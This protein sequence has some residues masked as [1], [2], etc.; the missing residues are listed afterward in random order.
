LVTIPQRG[1]RVSWGIPVYPA[2][3]DNPRPLM[4]KYHET[5]TGGQFAGL[6]LP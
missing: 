3:G 4:A 6:D 5:Q 1:S 2:S